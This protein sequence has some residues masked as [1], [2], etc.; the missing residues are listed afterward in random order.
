MTFSHF[1][2]EFVALYHGI[3]SIFSSNEH[4]IFLCSEAS[5]VYRSPWRLHEGVECFAFGRCS[6]S[7]A[8]DGSLS[9]GV[10]ASAL[11]VALLSCLNSAVSFSPVTLHLPTP[12]AT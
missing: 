11:L 6:T 8:T 7:S 9:V 4:D 5:A 2:N 10:A 1:T 3:F 12:A